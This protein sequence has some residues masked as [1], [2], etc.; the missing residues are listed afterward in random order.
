MRRFAT[1]SS[2]LFP[3]L[4]DDLPVFPS[5]NDPTSD[6]HLSVFRVQERA[7]YGRDQRCYARRDSNED[8]AQ[9]M[10][11]GISIS[12]AKMSIVGDKRFKVQEGMIVNRAIRQTSQAASCGVFHVMRQ[13]RKRLDE[14][15]WHA[16]IEKY[17]Y[18]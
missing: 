5:E 1:K 6:K 14:R 8:D 4:F 17:S 12:A 13:I 3:T 11:K 9:R 18:Q 7:K 15:K 2:K 16:L 10:R